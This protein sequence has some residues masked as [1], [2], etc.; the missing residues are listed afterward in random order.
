MADEKNKGSFAETQRR[1]IESTNAALSGMTLVTKSLT[2]DEDSVTMNLGEDRLITMPSYAKVTRDLDSLKKALNALLSGEGVVTLSDGTRRKIKATAVSVPPEVISELPTPKTFIVDANYFFEDMMFPRIKVAYNLEGVVDGF[3]DRV[4]VSRIILDAKSKEVMD[5]YNNVLPALSADDKKYI[6]MKHLLSDKGIAFYEDK[7]DVAL[8]LHISKV[9]GAFNVTNVATIEGKSFIQL[10]TLNYNEIDT[11][12]HPIRSLTLKVGDKLRFEDSVLNVLEVNNASSM[13]RVGLDIGGQYPFIESR[14]EIYSDPFKDKFVNIGV[15]FNEVNIIY[16][17]AI[18]EEYN[19][20]SKEWSTPTYFLTNDL[21]NEDGGEALSSYYGKVADFGA[22]MISEVK[23]GKIYAYNGHKPNAPSLSADYFGVARI[24]SQLDYT[25]DNDDITTTSKNMEL[26]RSRMASLKQTIA[27]QKDELQY[28][29]KNNTEERT[30]K[31]EQI[32]SNVKALKQN[33]V[34]YNSLLQHLNDLAVKNGITLSTPK[35]RLRGFFP[36]PDE[37]NGEKIIAF[38][39]SYRYLKLD[40]NGVELKTYRYGD[41]TSTTSGVYTDWITYRSKYLEKV[42]DEKTE[43]FIWKEESI[44]DGGAENINQINIP[45]QRGEKVEVRVRAVSEAG[46][47]ENALVSDWSNAVICEFPNNLSVGSRSEAILT[48]ARQEAIALQIDSALQEAGVYNHLEDEN[49]LFRHKGSAISVDVSDTNNLGVDL[50]QSFPKGLKDSP[51]T[52]ALQDYIT[53]AN[54]QIYL[55]T[56]EVIGMTKRFAD[57]NK[58]LKELEEKI[59]NGINVTPTPTPTPTPPEKNTERPKI[60]FDKSNGIYYINS[61]G[62]ALKGGGTTNGTGTSGKHLQ[63]KEGDK[64]NTNGDAIIFNMSW[65]DA[66]E[67]YLN[68]NLSLVVYEVNGDSNNGT[69]TKYSV[70]SGLTTT[71]KSKG[72]DVVEVSARVPN[73]TTIAGAGTKTYVFVPTITLTSPEGV[74]YSV[75]ANEFAPKEGY[76]GWFTITYEAK[77]NTEKPV[78]PAVKS[79]VLEK[80]YKADKSVLGRSYTKDTNPSLYKAQEGDY[81]APQELGEDPYL[82]VSGSPMANI[83]LKVKVKKN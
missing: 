72:N 21:V 58:E 82:L 46:Y 52:I 5:F 68:S 29:D 76:K 63:M 44:S 6:P 56:K 18:N 16:I 22:R 15:G 14:L 9:D 75:D 50:Q 10:N 54:S 64:Y 34:E 27:T 60:L 61:S 67:E 48:D 55:L 65:K 35:Y 78:T 26:V 73:N 49:A 4:L 30:K 33:Q 81:I 43:R 8:P 36:I 71:I 37:R 11:N 25:L 23:E 51:S 39:I 20:T 13:V 79:V 24:N 17:K 83:T 12:G 32:D 38:D 1:L 74:K 7:E 70:I 41:D 47:P 31:Q 59:K 77:G 66:S 19:I 40:N 53:K 3:A 80:G 69:F 62:R 57:V 28:I 42:Y 2:S 45:I